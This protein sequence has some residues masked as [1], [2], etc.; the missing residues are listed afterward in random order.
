MARRKPKYPDK[1]YAVSEDAR[2]R[3]EALMSPEVREK[4]KVLDKW[5]PKGGWQLWHWVTL[6]DVNF[7]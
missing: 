3:L 5:E 2:R 6:E 7:E 4:V 1:P